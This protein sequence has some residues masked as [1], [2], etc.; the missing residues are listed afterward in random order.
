MARV[1]RKSDNHAE[2]WLWQ[3]LRNRMMGGKFRRQYPIGKYIADFVC[4]ELHLVIE[5]DGSQ[6]I[7]NPNDRVRNRYMTEQGWSVARWQ[8]AK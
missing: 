5:L 1:L 6:H 7:D 2:S 3:N 4:V 8:Y